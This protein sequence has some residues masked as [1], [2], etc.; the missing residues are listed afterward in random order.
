[1]E[2]PK[3]SPSLKTRMLVLLGAACL[4]VSGTMAQPPGTPSQGSSNFAWK[5]RSP[6]G[7]DL[8]EAPDVKGPLTVKVGTKGRKNADGSLAEIKD[9]FGQ[10]TQQFTGADTYYCEL[11]PAIRAK[12]T[13]VE[14][15]I[16]P[17]VVQNADAGTILNIDGAVIGFAQLA[18]NQ[19]PAAFELLI[20]DSGKDGKPTWVKTGL[21][22]AINA[23]DHHP[24]PVRISVR[25][26]H[27]N[28]VWA[29]LLNNIVIDDFV[30][31]A[32]TES[33]PTF[34]ICAGA[35]QTVRLQGLT[36]LEGPPRGN[37][38]FTTE[39]SL[40]LAQARRNGAKD[41]FTNGETIVHPKRI[42]PIKAR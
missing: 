41:V 32:G 14:V 20:Q 11:D 31:L 38:R 16:R 8:G 26:D 17:A 27:K 2:P 19:G 3:F 25:L 24:A 39:A 12:V 13:F 15:K 30:A 29:L 6:D 23:Q 18:N 5:K 7:K 37:G 36:V 21:V 35:G 34:S 42:D 22:Y 40:D 28:K 1:M 4:L 9:V 33:K 10:T